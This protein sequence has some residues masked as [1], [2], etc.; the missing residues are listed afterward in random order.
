MNR[1]FL[2]LDAGT[3]S[4][5]AIIFDTMGNQ[6]SIAQYEWDHIAE[7]GVA[8]SMGFDF[9][10]GWELAKRCIKESVAK[11]QISPSEIVALSASSMREGIVVYDGNKNELW[12][13]ANVD[14]RA[15]EEVS[16]LK[17]TFPSLEKE[18]YAS[19]GQTFAL[20]AAPRLLWLKK[21]RPSLYEKAHS[22]TMISDWLLF[23][24]SGELASEPSNAGTAGAFSLKDRQWDKSEFEKCGLKDMFV[25]IKESGE[26]LGN[27]STQASDETGLSTKTLVVM[28]GGDVQIGTAGLGASKLGDAVVLGGSFWQQVV[29]IPSDA[30]LS[31]AMLLRVNPHVVRGMSQ[32]EGI[33][34]FTGLVMRW[35]KNTLGCGKSYSELEAMASSVP[36]GS[37]GITPVFSD[38]MNYGEWIHAS[39]SFIG[40]GL[41]ESKYNV[42]SMFRALEENA[43]IVS[44]INLENIK[45]FSGVSPTSITFASGASNG[46]LW[47][48]ILADVTG[49]EVKIPVVKE[50]TALGVAMAC[51][52]GAGVYNGFD[53][54]GKN[55]VKMER[56]Y[57]PNR[58][59]HAQY[60]EIKE[61]WLKV[62][63]KQMELVRE[64][65]VEPMWKAPGI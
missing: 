23:K 64:G 7:E 61:K 27:V 22:F 21:N 62:Y 12:G 44:S 29:N 17:K 18:S 36:L 38:R 11:A 46:A 16:Y 49:L 3:G 63:A 51:G 28:G 50:A 47:S 6:I 26:V 59:N 9:I 24:L 45:A 39:P 55:I 37:Y 53:E 43:C 58:S 15:G 42:A 4:I 19:S 2:V 30:T 20:S 54:A 31:D 10:R 8:G 33:T 32:A 40:L 56:S 52:I 34:F 25:P 60:G 5:R 14:G 41:D 35:F 65:I 1:Y 48:Q 13:V 57:E